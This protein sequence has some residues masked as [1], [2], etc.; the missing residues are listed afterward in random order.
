M[1]RSACS[2]TSWPETSALKSG[3]AV[4]AARP[5]FDKIL[6]TAHERAKKAR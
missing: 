2:P 4:T 3:Q 6:L 5:E 1:S